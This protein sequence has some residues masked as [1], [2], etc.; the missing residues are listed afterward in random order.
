LERGAEIT[1]PKTAEGRIDRTEHA[2][3][4][5]NKKTG[6]TC[7]VDVADAGNLALV[8]DKSSYGRF[9]GLQSTESASQVG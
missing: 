7:P 8:H 1:P 2:K 6:R 4:Q 5:A 3:L 9:A